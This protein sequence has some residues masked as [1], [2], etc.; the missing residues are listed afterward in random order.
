MKRRFILAALCTAAALM[1]CSCMMKSNETK[2]WA[3]QDS[4]GMR[5]MAS[6]IFP[7]APESLVAEL[8]FENGVPSA[9]CAYFVQRDG[10]NLLFDAGNGGA[11]SRLIPELE[12][13]GIAPEDIDCLFLTH[14]HGDHTGGMLKDGKAVFTNATIYLNK[15]EYAG[16]GEGAKEDKV[17]EAYSDRL[18]LFDATE[19]LPHGITPIKAYGHTPGHT[20]YTF[21]NI[22]IAGDIMHGLALQFDHPEICAAFDVDKPSAVES[23]KMVIELVKSGKH[24]YGMHFPAPHYIVK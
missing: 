3:I 12:K 5:M 8:G 23:R 15:D 2:M 17:L 6:A 20:I 21:D 13:L 24:V 18:V 7:D 22:V 9:I 1:V 19:E 10:A 14:L 4:P 16:S 11:D